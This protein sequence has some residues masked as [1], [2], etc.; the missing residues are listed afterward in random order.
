MN[1]RFFF[2]RSAKAVVGAA[3]ALHLIAPTKRIG[4]I[5]DTPHQIRTI[6]GET[7]TLGDGSEYFFAHTAEQDA[8]LRRLL[9]VLPS[10]HYTE[11]DFYTQYGKKG[12]FCC[13]GHSEG[14]DDPSRYCCIILLP[15]TAGHPAFDDIRRKAERY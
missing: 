6:S 10:P 12:V 2:E 15:E 13:D 7:V 14:T 5:L 3:V 11:A 4:Y 9:N 8:E 1:R